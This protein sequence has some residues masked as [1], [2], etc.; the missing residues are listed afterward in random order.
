MD[1]NISIVLSVSTFILSLL[2]MIIGFFLKKLV[3]KIDDSKETLINL[4]KTVALIQRDIVFFQKEIQN[5][6]DGEKTD[7]KEI[8]KIREK[9]HAHGNIL[10]GLQ[11]KVG[12]IDH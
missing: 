2:M 5:I 11:L 12:E 3:D 4:D 6:E 1:S 7:R 9:L 10:N 8:E